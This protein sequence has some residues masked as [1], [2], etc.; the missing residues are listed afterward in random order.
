MMRILAYWSDG[1]ELLPSAYPWNCLPG[2]SL[3]LTLRD[4]AQAQVSLDSNLVG[5]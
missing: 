4:D 3:R 5:G 2:A 1:P